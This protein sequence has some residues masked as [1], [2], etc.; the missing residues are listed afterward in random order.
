[1]AEFYGLNAKAVLVMRSKEIRI[2]E[3]VDKDGHFGPIDVVCQFSNIPDF[4]NHVFEGFEVY[5]IV[6]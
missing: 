5:L 6:A 1:M 3:L 4:S 2:E